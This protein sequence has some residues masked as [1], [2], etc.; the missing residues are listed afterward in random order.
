[1]SAGRVDQFTARRLSTPQLLGGA[2]AL[3]GAAGAT[4]ALGGKDGFA[5]GAGLAT[6]SCLVW[7]ETETLVGL[8]LVLAL[9][10]PAIPTVGGLNCSDFVLLI[11]MGK[12]AYSRQRLH[13]APRYGGLVLAL[14]FLAEAVVTVFGQSVTAQNPRFIVTLAGLSLAAYLVWSSG[15]PERFIRWLA[16][17]SGAAAGL[18]GA[19][20]AAYRLGGVVLFPT[21]QNL[22]FIDAHI[23]N[24]FRATG[25]GLDPNFL[26]LWIVPGLGIAAIGL[27]RSKRRLEYG[28]YAALCAFGVFATASRGS[29]IS[30]IVGL[31][32]VV[33]VELASARRLPVVRRRHLASA[34]LVAVLLAPVVFVEVEHAIARYPLTAETRV[35]QV[36][37]VLKAAVNGNWAGLGFEAEADEIGGITT[38]SS[39]FIGAENVVHNTLLQALYEDGWIGFL[40]A[41]LLLVSGL[42]IALRFLRG[43]SRSKAMLGA[44]FVVLSV[45]LQVLGAYA[46]RP[47]W[48]TWA[49]LLAVNATA[50]RGQ[51]ER[52]LVGRAT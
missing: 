18:A 36:P 47:M 52:R 40:G 38:I 5:A 2:V 24:T 8:W 7:L 15:K 46:F 45:N 23:S 34:C 19:Q 48:F 49:L 43:A 35:N 29:L 4:A 41:L 42:R 6:A 28:L 3:A 32:I 30:A 17:A 37:V 39:P 20:Y 26:G 21:V 9:A 22:F 50:Q 51:L 10:D 14:A 1:M 13:R 44:A 31:A 25:L 12:F 33:Y 27:L 11:A 16:I